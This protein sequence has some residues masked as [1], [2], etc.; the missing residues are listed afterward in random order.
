MAQ[1]DSLY[2]PIDPLRPPAA[3]PGS[4]WTS[5]HPPLNFDIIFN[6]LFVFCAKSFFDRNKSSQHQS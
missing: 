2:E 1:W 4:P 5:K 6:F 3:P